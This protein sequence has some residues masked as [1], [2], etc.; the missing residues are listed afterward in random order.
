MSW[1]PLL[2]K[3]SRT[4]TSESAKRRILANEEFL[5]KPT[6]LSGY[7]IAVVIATANVDVVVFIIF[8]LLLLL[9]LLLLVLL[10]SSQKKTSMLIRI[11]LAKIIFAQ[12]ELLAAKYVDCR[13][14]HDYLLGHL[15]FGR[16]GTLTFMQT[17]SRGLVESWQKLFLL[18][19]MWRS[20][21]NEFVF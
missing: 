11:P 2:L 21:Q 1:P 12:V 15:P 14:Y 17:S 18:V 10:C 7:C 5:T 6:S 19:R 20:Q 4:H 8:L 3:S 9:M 16:N 13:H